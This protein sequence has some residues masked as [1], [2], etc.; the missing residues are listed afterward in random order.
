VVHVVETRCCNWLLS[1][2]DRIDDDL[3]PM[4]HADLAELLGVQ[5][6]TVSTVLRMFQTQSLI[7]EQ[8]GS[9]VIA[10]RTGL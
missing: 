1:T 6:S 2:R 5:R 9:I 3:L 4:T 7:T 8:R 10:D